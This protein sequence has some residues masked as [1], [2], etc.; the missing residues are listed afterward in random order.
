MLL[1]IECRWARASDSSVLLYP[2]EAMPRTEFPNFSVDLPPD[3][4]DTTPDVEPGDRPAT[5]TRHHGVGALQFSIGLYQS[6]PRPPGDAKQ[7]QEFLDSFAKSHGWTTPSEMVRETSPRALVAASFH[8]GDDFVRVWYVSEH[9][10]FAYVTYTCA[11][12]DLEP[13]E[14]AQAEQIVRSV[15]FVGPA[16]AKIDTGAIKRDNEAIIREYGG[17]ICEWLPTPDP[18][19][20]QRGVR[21]V[22]S[23]ARALRRE[24]LG[25]VQTLATVREIA[26]LAGQKRYDE[27]LAH[28]R[29]A[30]QACA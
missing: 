22:A 23:R 9:G 19:A 15:L 11:R 26:L 2:A 5:I 27:I 24:L 8:P 20:P 3:W 18:D 21:E 7:L 25:R 30:G 28:G 6:G 13:R 14:L 10:N 16:K 17:Q 1:V 4:G 29:C 12:A